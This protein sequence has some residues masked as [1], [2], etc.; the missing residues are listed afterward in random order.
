M[1]RLA[2]YFLGIIMCCYTVTACAQSKSIDTAQ[3]KRLT[4]ELTTQ[5]EFKGDVYRYLG[6]SIKYPPAAKE[7]AIN[8]RVWVR[9]LIDENG[10]V[11]TPFIVGK[12]RLGGGLEEEALRVVKAMPNWKPATYN[13]KPVRVVYTLPVAFKLQ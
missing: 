4:D 7:N 5:A 3:A 13:G 6:R 12:R 9:F 11:N 10:S 1:S 8:G 2:R